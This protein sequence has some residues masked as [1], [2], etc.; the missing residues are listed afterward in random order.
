MNDK[1]IKLE[2]NIDY[3]DYLKINGFVDNYN[4]EI[5]LNKKLYEHG[6][7]HDFIVGS[8]KNEIEKIKS[9]DEVFCEL[10]TKGFV[11]PIKLKNNLKEILKTMGLKQIDLEDMTRI[12][13][14]DINNIVNNR[15]IMSLDHFLRIWICLGCPDIDKVFYV[16][17]K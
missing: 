15:K 10:K 8:I 1:K 12:T 7:V 4:K 16:D 14:S 3:E 17:R 6:T 11:R 9:H 13:N 2:I 5:E